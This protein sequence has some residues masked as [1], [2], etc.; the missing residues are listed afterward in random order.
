MNR[1]P[2]VNDYPC[3]LAE[4]QKALQVLLDT[5]S[6]SAATEV[7]PGLTED[8]LVELLRAFLPQKSIS[9]A[10]DNKNYDQ[11]VEAERDVVPASGIGKTV[12]LYTD[13]AS[14]G[15]PGLAGAGFLILDE[16]STLLDEGKL[17]L[18]ERTNN[19]AEYD[20]LIAGL[21]LARRSGCQEV[22]VRADS[23]LMIRQL[24]GQYRVKNKRLIPLVLEVKKLAAAFAKVTYHHVPRAD[25]ARADKLANQ[26]IDEEPKGK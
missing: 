19:E 23:Q 13:G 18:G 24:T 26:A 6:F 8:R 2:K 10:E 9:E 17:F 11:R 12:I 5:R 20:A 25:N 16:T 15:N 1:K 14:R 22:E 7:V 4:V 21:K 3:T